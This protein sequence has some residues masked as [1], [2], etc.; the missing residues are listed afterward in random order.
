MAAAHF[1][2]AMWEQRRICIARAL[3]AHQVGRVLEVGCGEGNIL[4]FLVAPASDDEHPITH[5]YGIDISADALSQARDRLEPTGQDTRDLRVDGLRV[6]LFCGSAMAPAAPIDI[7]AVVCSEVIEH[8]QESEVPALTHAVLGVYRPRLAVFTTPNAE[9]NANFP[10]LCYGTPEARFRNADHKFEWTRNEFAQWAQKAAEHYGYQVELRGIG[11]TMRNASAEFVPCG[12]CSQMALFVRVAGAS[13]AVEPPP[14]L[15]LAPCAELVPFASFDYPVFAQ[16]QL[17]DVQLLALVLET[18]R[19]VAD[20]QRAFALADLWSVQEVR[21]HF[22][23]R[24]AL[25]TWLLDNPQHFAPAC[26]QSPAQRYAL[27][28]A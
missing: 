16:P 5:L 14:G 21:H 3:Y 19:F 8:V 10:A 4:S 20:E 28:S 2:P 23:R 11:M 27:T 24:L 18:A 13:A 1:W 9:F 7:D 15:V 25:Q 17:P 22:K 26:Q 6:E 12:G